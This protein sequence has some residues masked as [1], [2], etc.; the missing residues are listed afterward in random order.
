[1]FSDSGVG[2][3]SFGTVGSTFT[4]FVLQPG[5]Y[6]VHLSIDNVSPPGSTLQMFLNNAPGP[7]LQSE[8][9]ISFAGVTMG[10]DRLLA[11]ATA[12]TALSF[13]ATGPNGPLLIGGSDCILIITQLQ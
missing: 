4:N 7:Y 11:V 10:G 9:F 8:W 12:N 6:Q 1:V 5:L 2:V 13:Q 3:G